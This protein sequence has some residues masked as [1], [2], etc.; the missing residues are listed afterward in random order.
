MRIENGAKVS[1]DWD[2]ILR[3]HLIGS[4]DP[5]ATRNLI[6]KIGV[7]RGVSRGGLYAIEFDV[8]SS[9]SHDCCGM[10]D[11]HRGLWISPEAVSPL[12]G[13]IDMDL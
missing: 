10:T 6:G 1:I 11:E 7:I 4:E 8:K 5:G 13:D 3:E 12:I 9:L 2:L